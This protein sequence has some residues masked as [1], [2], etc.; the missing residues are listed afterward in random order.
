MSYAIRVAR[1]SAMGDPGLF[2]FLGKAAGAV[3]GV[4]GNV[5]PG[6][7]GGIAKI[8]S[9]LL[10]PK[11]ISVAKAT[12]G[13]RPGG[14]M[15]SG[16]AQPLFQP[17][18]Q[19][20]FST[21]RI[22]PSPIP[23]LPVTPTSANSGRV[24]GALVGAGAGTPCTSGY[25]Y[26]K[27]EYYTKRYGVVSKGSVCVKNRR[28]NPLNP[29]ALSRAMSRIKSAQKAVRCLG[30]FAGAP[31]RAAKA[32]RNGRAPRRGGSCKRCK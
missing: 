20:P 5:L 26:N 11:P 29:R 24:T 1:Q 7:L 8:G 32:S 27:T 18:G 25:H 4:A 19:A 28:R 2:S 12:T 31:A 22:A 10:A 14:V 15:V 9:Q 6:P 17:V 3:L 16:V 13:M 21:A 30:L 23:M